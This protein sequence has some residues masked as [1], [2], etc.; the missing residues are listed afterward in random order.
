M[1]TRRIATIVT[2]VVVLTSLLAVT[3]QA[4]IASEAKQSPTSK[5]EIASAQTARLLR[6]LS[7]VIASGAKQSP[8]L[9]CK[10]RWGLLRRKNRLLAMTP[11]SFCPLEWRA[12]PWPTRNDT[13]WAVTLGRQLCSS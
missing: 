8:A 3:T 10:Q 13:G 9:K 2:V 7:T 4:V 5:R 12:P 1:Q 6:N 11:G